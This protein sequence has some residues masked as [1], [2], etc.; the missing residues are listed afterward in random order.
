MTMYDAS[1]ASSM[2]AEGLMTRG[3]AEHMT[4]ERHM[5]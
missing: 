3:K 4:L 1:A 5:T 2:M